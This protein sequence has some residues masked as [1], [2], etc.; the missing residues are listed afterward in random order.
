MEGF[1]A[2]MP[3]GFTATL[4]RAP[5]RF[6]RAAVV[7]WLMTEGRLLPTTEAL[8]EAF[9]R[10]LAAEGVPLWRC[11]LQLRMLHPLF[12]GVSFFWWRERAGVE[13]V[14]RAHG[15]E[16]DPAY[17]KSPVAAIALEG[18][19]GIH[20]RL[21]TSGGPFPYAILQELKA[22]G[23][24]D[25]A[26]MPIRFASGRRNV[27]TFASNVPGGFSTE[28][29]A[30]IDGVLPALGSVLETQALRRLSTN[31]LNTYVGPLTGARI[32]SGEIRR[33]VG[34]TLRAVLFYCDLRGFTALADRLPIDEL[35]GLLNGYYEIMGGAV[36]ARGGEILKF[37]G[38]AMLAI[39]PLAHHG[40]DAEWKEAAACRLALAA[41][42]DA[43]AEMG[44][45]NAERRAWGQPTL[46]AGIALHVGDV[47]YG[48]IGAPNR[49]DFT[50]IG[51]A[52]NLVNRLEGLCT[53]MDRTILTSAEL[54]RAC[55]QELVSLGFQPVK[56]LSEPVE[57]F[58]R[59][60]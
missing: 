44:R 21:E 49:L 13:V 42:D 53:R 3:D 47:M 43:V 40:G 54:A 41:A 59:S 46:R 4:E 25:Y 1:L 45:L 23:G 9:C 20:H 30:L 11:S 12:F 22:Q 38:D 52:V 14:E 18:V 39:F 10:R 26:A 7:D 5:G 31:L 2:V 15:G 37:V 6:D 33:G 55:P 19:E 24:T 29:L 28:A 48:N 51:P 36:Q 57:V 27:V 60:G 32:L 56:G 17:L 58:G 8:M 16:S 50:V 35:I 34:V